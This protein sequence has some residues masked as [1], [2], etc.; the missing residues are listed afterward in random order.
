MMER[1]GGGGVDDDAYIFG[2]PTERD[3]VKSGLEE[4]MNGACQETVR[5]S[6][7]IGCNYRIAAYVNAIRKIQTTYDSGGLLLA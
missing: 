4:T 5:T 3:I 2:G 6:G 1:L 7:E